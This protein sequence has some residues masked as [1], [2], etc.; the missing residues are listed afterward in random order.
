VARLV[1]VAAVAVI[2]VAV[3][4]MAG[5]AAPAAAQGT[6]LSDREARLTARLDSL[7]ARMEATPPESRRTRV[8]RPL[9]P[10]DT[11]MV[12]GLRVIA[13]TEDAA[14]AARWARDGLRPVEARLG[15]LP[16]VPDPPTIRVDWPPAT[17]PY[18][19]ANNWVQIPRIATPDEV[20]RAFDGT[21][22]EVLVARLPDPVQ[23]WLA[24]PL[25]TEARPYRELAASPDSLVRDCVAGDTGACAVALGL[26]PDNDV[27]VRPVVRR[28]FLHYLLR[29]RPGA[30]ERLMTTDDA[31][32]GLADLLERAAGGPLDPVVA[33]WRE[34]VL[35]HP[36][37]ALPA[38]V[39][40]TSL[41]WI[42]LFVGLATRSTRWR[43]G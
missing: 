22:G 40:G 29:T 14:F 19:P 27:V 8:E 1:A 17:V 42:L 15:P 28:S 21:L 36:P 18:D 11:A 37:R 26:H 30:L 33:G 25:G 43:G 16:T 34:D 9:P 23:A 41:F 3:T 24:G 35:A 6:P 31:H 5:G 32:T 4:S 7:R 2:A 12:R 13:P 39:V 20:A 10:L 38:S